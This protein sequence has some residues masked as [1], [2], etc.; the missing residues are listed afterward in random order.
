MS[1]KTQ[2][3]RGS[4]TH[5]RG[6]KKK[7]RGAGG[8]GGKGMAGTGKHRF[9]GREYFGKHGFTHPTPGKKERVINIKD[10]QPDTKEINLT[11]EGYD[12]LLG[13]GNITTPIKITVKKASKKAEEKIIKAGGTIING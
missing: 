3:Y 9:Q 1:S 4:K 2:K 10:L 12:K 13:T 5:G 11:K 6:S 8:K 7:G